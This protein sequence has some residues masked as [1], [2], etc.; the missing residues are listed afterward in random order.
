M[1]LQE[2][3]KDWLR[4][5]DIKEMMLAL[6]KVDKARIEPA[7]SDIFKAFT[8]CSFDELKV[9]MLGQDPYP[10]KGVSTGIAFGNKKGTTELSP[11]LQILKEACID[12]TVPH[13]SVEFDETL[14][15]WGKQ[16]V[17]LLN[18]ALT[19]VTNKPNS[20]AMIW[21]PFISKMLQNCS[22]M[23]T[24]LVY[25]LFGNQAQTFE[26][27]I[28]K[29]FNDVIKVQHPAYYARIHKP[30]PHEVFKEIDRLLI[31]RYNSSI[32]WYGEQKN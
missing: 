17:L 19:V 15:S 8:L 4:V 30:M 1:T 26:P 11:S 32:E 25:V 24:G 13:Y 9:I 22:K 10:Q 5:I 2:Y 21:R 12:Y 6:S 28:D 20:N 27:Y 14:E 7:F 31:G 29:R 16:G 3:F 18:S 23:E